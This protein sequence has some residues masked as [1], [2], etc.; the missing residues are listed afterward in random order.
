RGVGQKLNHPPDQKLTQGASKTD[1]PREPCNPTYEAENLPAASLAAGGSSRPT[2][3]APST[4]LGSTGI[5][6]LPP[7]EWRDVTP[8]KPDGITL[9]SSAGPPSESYDAE[10][11]RWLATPKHLRWEMPTRPR[12][13][14]TG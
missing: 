12:G 1:P 7:S 14:P 10:L 8:P 3:P 11:R 13:N 9:P 4:T 5:I 6:D 2:L